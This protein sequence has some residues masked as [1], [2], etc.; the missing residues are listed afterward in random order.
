MEGGASPDKK[1]LLLLDLPPVT[2]WT[3]AAPPHPLQ[4]AAQ[5]AGKCSPG[6][7]AVARPVVPQATGTR[8]GQGRRRGGEFWR[9][10]GTALMDVGGGLWGGGVWR[11]AQEASSSVAVPGAARRLSGVG[12]S[13]AV[14]GEFRPVSSRRGAAA[15]CAGGGGRQGP[16]GGRARAPRSPS[17]PGVSPR[18]GAG[19][20]PGRAGPGRGGGGRLRQAGRVPGPLALRC[21]ARQGEAAWAARLRPAGPA[22]PP[23]NKGRPWAKAPGRGGTS[24]QRP[25]L[26]SQ[27]PG[28]APDRS[29]EDGGP[30]LRAALPPR[31]AGL[32]ARELELEPRCPLALAAC[33]V[34]GWCPLTNERENGNPGKP[35]EE[36]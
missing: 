3:S 22:L 24:P 34:C 21:A 15:L 7:E 28:V 17:D 33:L 27:A 2:S 19:A 30:L 12:W 35:C 32:G 4:P 8:I 10:A 23:P 29:A 36:L 14:R 18:A 16:G 25:L 9:G 5:H 20:G 1:P 6:S 11:A 31:R 13:G 26:S